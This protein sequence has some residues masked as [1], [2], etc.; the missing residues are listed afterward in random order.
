MGMTNRR[1]I[2][3]EQTTQADRLALTSVP[4][5]RIT[6]VGLIPDNEGDLEGAHSLAIRIL[7]G[8]YELHLRDPAETQEVHDL[9]VW[10]LIVN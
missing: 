10:R 9:L 8:I 2:L 4:L 7:A 1:V 5:T 3:L 6:S